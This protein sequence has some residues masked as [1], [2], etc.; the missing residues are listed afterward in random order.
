[1]FQRLFFFLPND[2]KLLIWLIQGDIG[3]SIYYPTEYQEPWV[4]FSYLSGKVPPQIRRCRSFAN[5]HISVSTNHRLD[6]TAGVCV[7]VRNANV[8]GQVS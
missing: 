3:Y 8:S 6:P 7:G 1:M 2:T 4:Q 5:N